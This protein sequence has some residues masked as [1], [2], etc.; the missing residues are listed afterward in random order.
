MKLH[1]AKPMMKR[2]QALRI[3]SSSVLGGVASNMARQS[4]WASED[5]SSLVVH[6]AEEWKFLTPAA[7]KVSNKPLRTHLEEV[8][9]NVKRYP[10]EACF[11]TRPALYR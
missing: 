3:I 6:E 4:A 1:H 7:F 11:L 9:G 5:T 10:Y 2:A 8:G